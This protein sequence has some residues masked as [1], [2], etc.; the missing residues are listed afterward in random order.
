MI[1][2]PVKY[3]NLAKAISGGFRKVRYVVITGGRGSSKSFSTQTILCDACI[4]ENNGILFTRYTMKSAHKSIIPEFREKVEL[5]NANSLTEETKEDIKF[6]HN[7][8]L[9]SFSG[10]KTSSGDQ[11]A[12]LK[13]LKGYNV[14][15]L[16]EAEELRDEEKFDDIQLS[17]R[18]GNKVNLIVIILNPTTKEHWVYKRFF[19][20]KGVKEGYNGNKG[21]T[22]YIHTTY[23]DNY[24]NLSKSFI[25]DVESLKKI[26]PKKYKHKILGGWLEKAEGVIYENWAIGEFKDT[27]ISAYGL[28]FGFS[29][30]PTA[31]VHVSV[32]KNLKK[33]YVKLLCYRPKMST[34]DI[35]NE[36]KQC[37][38]RLIVADNSE[39]RLI[40]ELKQRRYNVEACEKGAG[41]ITAGISLIQDYELIVDEKSIDIVKELNNYVWNDKKSKL[42]IDDYNHALDAIRYA[43]K[44]LLKGQISYSIQRARTGKRLVG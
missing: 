6:S 21:D 42:P 35:A 28:D 17:F 38:K 37:D 1:N 12:N 9:I 23:L 31:L 33:I 26:N 13:S 8:S 34:D 4:R 41:S 10:I 27:G 30:D 22:C 39:S 32:D 44:R 40:S 11:T 5:L 18:D 19:E 24:N 14:W 25:D 3:N 29:V 15:V 16:E 20:N 43:V 7:G 2:I 36:L